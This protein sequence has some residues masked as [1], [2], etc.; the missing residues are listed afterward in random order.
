MT[1]A[2]RCADPRPRA[3]RDSFAGR[4]HHVYDGSVS[5][6]RRPATGQIVS[7]PLSL[8]WPGRRAGCRVSSQIS[9]VKGAGARRLR[10]RLSIGTLC[11]PIETIT[12]APAPA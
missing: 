4:D 3:D 11:R 8:H 10:L 5:L 9:F 1:P 6:R 12:H 7:L 2:V